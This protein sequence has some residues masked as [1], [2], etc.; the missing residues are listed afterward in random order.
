MLL[1]MPYTL[2]CR[3]SALIDNGIL[4]KLV[5][6]FSYVLQCAFLLTLS[7][8]EE[9]FA[10]AYLLRMCL[11]LVQKVEESCGKVKDSD[12]ESILG[13]FRDLKTLIEA[14]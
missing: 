12:A 9:A 3:F 1:L 5:R 14:A 13:V 8:A 6:I 7:R 10:C 4:L 11:C 2:W